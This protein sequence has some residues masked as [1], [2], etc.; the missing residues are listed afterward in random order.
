[1]KKKVLIVD[2]DRVFSSITRKKLSKYS[3]SFLVLTAHDG[4][5]AVEKLS[6]NTIS[7]VVT[8]LE[9]PNMDGFELL[10]FLSGNYPDIPVMILTAHG[11]PESEQAVMKSG[12]SG[13]IRKPVKI[14]LLARAIIAFLRRESEGGIFKANPLK[15]YVQLIEKEKKTCTVRVVRRSTGQKGTLFFRDGELLLARIHHQQGTAAAVHIL[16]WRNVILSMQNSCAYTEKLVD[17][18]LSTLMGEA[19]KKREQARQADPPQDE[20]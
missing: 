10:A 12:G 16:G 18:D 1:M 14:D 5:H 4:R 8:D 13:L 11:S 9:M 17:A 3:D 19:K 7:L 2:D 6:K 20:E 15:T